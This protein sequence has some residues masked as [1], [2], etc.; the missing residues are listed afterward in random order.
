MD[1]R[2]MTDSLKQILQMLYA[3]NIPVSVI[4]E[5]K[6]ICLLGGKKGSENVAVI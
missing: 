2:M 6:L 5:D 1:F 4:R 3:V